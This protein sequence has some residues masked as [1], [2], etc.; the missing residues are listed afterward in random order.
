M[1]Q[2]CE[3]YSLELLKMLCVYLML[4]EQRY[5]F[6]VCVKKPYITTLLILQ[7]LNHFLPI[8]LCLFLKSEQQLLLT[9]FFSFQ[10]LFSLTCEI[11]S[12]CTGL[13]ELFIL[14]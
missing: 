7:S 13:G 4:P 2:E 14:R 5:F 10:L 6:S 1:T 3:C 11:C 12:D 9:L 8:F